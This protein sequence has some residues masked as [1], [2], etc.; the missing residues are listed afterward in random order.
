MSTYVREITEQVKKES[1]TLER[2]KLEIRSAAKTHLIYKVDV[3]FNMST[4]F[5]YSDLQERLSGKYGEIAK[6]V[7]NI[8]EEPIFVK[9]TTDYSKWHSRS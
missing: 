2:V 7:N 1:A 9:Y 3:Y 8:K 4:Q 5:T 6:E